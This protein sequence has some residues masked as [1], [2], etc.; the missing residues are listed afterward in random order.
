M[1]LSMSRRILIS[2][3]RRISE[4]MNNIKTSVPKFLFLAILFFFI[5]G[6][7]SH[8]FCKMHVRK[9]VVTAQYFIILTQVTILISF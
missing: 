4:D 2:V 6:K 9:I 7:N 8:S 3:V 1:V 5:L